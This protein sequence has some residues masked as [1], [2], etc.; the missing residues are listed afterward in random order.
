MR[1]PDLPD[2]VRDLAQRL[3]ELIEANRRRAGF[4]ASVVEEDTLLDSVTALVDRRTQAPTR[5]RVPPSVQ[6]PPPAGV[7]FPRSRDRGDPRQGLAALAPLAS[8]LP[9]AR[10][11][12]D[13]L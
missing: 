12:G 3:T 8:S 6:R 1:W 2:S 13:P 7:F 11:G 10:T 9:A 4:P 5:P